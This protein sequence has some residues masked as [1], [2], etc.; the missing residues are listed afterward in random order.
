MNT[1]QLLNIAAF[2]SA[3]SNVRRKISSIFDTVAI[4][5]GTTFYNPF[6]TAPGNIFLRNQKFPL[7]G[8]QLFWVTSVSMFLAQAIN[9]PALYAA[10][11]PGLQSSNIELLIDSK[12]YFKMPLIE[13][14]SF[15][16]QNQ[17][18]VT[19]STQVYKVN[20]VTRN[21]NLIIPVFINAASNVV[22]NLNLDSAFATA[23]NSNN[24]LIS[25]NGILTDALDASLNYNPVQGNNL[26][27]IAYTMY[28]TQQ[29]TT[30]NANTFNF[31]STPETN[32]NNY[33]K[34]LPLSSTERFELQAL[35]V[36][37]GGNAGTT[38]NFNDV[39]NQRS[40]NFLNISVDDVVYHQSQLKDY[41]SIMTNNN[42]G[43]FGD[44]AS[45][46]VTTEIN[47]T[48]LIYQNKTLEIPVILPAQGKVSVTIQQPGS[49]LNQNE[50]ITLMLKGLIKRQVN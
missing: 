20:P 6:Q 26:Q 18:G 8:Q 40:T 4:T 24:L 41:L 38:D 3:N 13:C 47:A 35:E 46:A 44:D 14:L 7:S 19:G 9:T 30:A 15:N 10:L 5:S 28:D 11:L 48:Q 39:F 32:P 49:S 42:N 22:V 34:I 2:P 43:K 37:I 25:L 16:I 31:F 33:N 45:P 1:T 27:D 29:I 50:Y 23:F 17:V 12:Q 21:K 36:F